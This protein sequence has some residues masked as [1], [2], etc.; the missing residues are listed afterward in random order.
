MY[1]R[2]RGL[3]LAGGTLCIILVF[4]F[5]GSAYATCVKNVCVVEP[6]LGDNLRSGTISYVELTMNWDRYL[7]PVSKYKLFYTCEGSDFQKG[8]KQIWR[9]ITTRYCNL[10]YGC[11][12]EYPW[13]VPFVQTAGTLVRV[14][15]V[16]VVVYD[17]SGKKLGMHISGRFRILPYSP[18]TS[19]YFIP[20][21][22]IVEPKGW[23]VYTI[24]GGTP[25]YKVTTSNPGITTI[26]GL[27]PPQIFRAPPPVTISI[28]NSFTSPC[29]DTEVII[30]LEDRYG[31]RA[32]A[33]YFINC[34]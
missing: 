30:L 3:A 4:L 28:E 11:P 19:P 20:F 24:F 34:P 33:T 1:K 7:F 17:E 25:P 22:Q 29:E 9:P 21:E 18:V 6:T 32:E 31:T 10:Y 14:C 27:T 8:G 12:L 15:A 26:N 16:G 5:V 2:N 13:E 23:T